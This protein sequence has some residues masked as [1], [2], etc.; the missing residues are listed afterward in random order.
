[1]NGADAHSRSPAFVRCRGAAIIDAG[2]S[3]GRLRQPGW[4]E[5]LVAWEALWRRFA[6]DVRASRG[7]E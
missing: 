3:G 5:F 7:A 6:F 1:M 4:S 2:L